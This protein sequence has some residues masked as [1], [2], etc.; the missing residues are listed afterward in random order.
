MLLACVMFT[1]DEALK[2][3]LSFGECIGYVTIGI[4]FNLCKICERVS[5][6]EDGCVKV[7][8]SGSV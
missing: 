2:P 5:E 7:Y 3:Y 4:L 8:F 6:M 1:L